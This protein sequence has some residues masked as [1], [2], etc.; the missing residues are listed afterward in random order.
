MKTNNI[1]TSSYALL[2]LLSASLGLDCRVE[3]IQALTEAEWNRLIDIS[4]D[5]G[6][7]ALAVD[8]YHSL[9]V[10]TLLDEV[11]MRELRYEWFA[12]V[13]Q[14]EDEY[15]YKFIRAARF[16]NALEQQDVQCRVLKGMSFAT[17]YRCPDHRECGDCDVYLG[18]GFETGNDVALQLGGKYEFGTYKHSHLY[19]GKLMVENHR[20]LTDF[21]GTRQGRKTELLLESII[22]E[23]PGKKIGDSQLICPNDHFNALFLI[24]HAHGNFLYGGLTLRMIY[25]WAALLICCQDRLD[26]KLLNEEFAECRLLP[27]AHLMTSLCVDYLDVRLSCEDIGLCDDPALVAEVMADTLA[28]GIH[29]R[30][31]ETFPKKCLRISR[32]FRR[33]WHF[34]HLATES[35]PRLIWNNFAFSSYLKRKIE[36]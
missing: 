5:S 33:I 14:V 18:S 3:D 34:R 32:R 1:D 4:F 23:A 36:M 26:W 6:V 16:A 29:T 15:K 24:K 13:L 30:G 28:G 11:R 2:G 17:Y 25:D 8:G 20:Y 22:D 35:V 27:F 19:F 12:S 9:G 31:K 7:A 10:E 21:N